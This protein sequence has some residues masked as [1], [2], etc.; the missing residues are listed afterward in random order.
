MFT[1]GDEA[2]A[3]GARELASR[4]QAYVRQIEEIPDVTLEMI[5]KTHLLKCLRSC[6]SEYDVVEHDCSADRNKSYIDT[7]RDIQTRFNRL[8]TSD[9]KSQVG[10]EGYA[11]D[12]E[13]CRICGE[14]G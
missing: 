8:S 14:Y 7:I 11:L 4:H 12:P 13:Q 5:W 2:G 10:A 3:C 6:G 1:L 9:S